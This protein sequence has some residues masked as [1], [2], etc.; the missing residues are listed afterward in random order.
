MSV[1]KVGFS[2]PGRLQEGEE[3]GA[4]FRLYLNEHRTSSLNA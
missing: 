2:A 3:E 4:E 1:Q